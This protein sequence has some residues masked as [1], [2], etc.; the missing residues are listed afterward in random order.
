MQINNHFTKRTYD[1]FRVDYDIKLTDIE[2]SYEALISALNWYITNIYDYGDGSFIITLEYEARII[3][4]LLEDS[5]DEIY[6][7]S[8]FDER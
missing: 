5:E 2:P 7:L 6:F 8:Y 3:V 4:E 1:N